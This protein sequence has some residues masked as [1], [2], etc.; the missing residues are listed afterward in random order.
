[1]RR[2][3][4]AVGVVVLAVLTGAGAVA[5]SLGGDRNQSTAPSHSQRARPPHKKKVAKEPASQPCQESGQQ[6]AAQTAVEWDPVTCWGCPSPEEDVGVFLLGL[7]VYVPIC[8]GVIR[9][10]T[11][12]REAEAFRR[13]LTL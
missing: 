6:V 10:R 11:R 8:I 5:G 3:T 7:L 12:R 2:G 13:L 1:M 4:A 9:A